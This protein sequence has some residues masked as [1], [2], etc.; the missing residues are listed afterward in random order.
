MN[1]EKR[2]QVFVSST[3]VDLKKEREEVLQALLELDCIPSGMEL[4]PAADETQWDLIKRL[5]DDCDY[6][7]LIIGG[8]YGSIGPDGYSYTEM[9]Y[10]YALEINKPTIA[11]LHRSPGSLSADNT[12]KSDEGRAKLAAFRAFAEQ[13]LC[14]HWEGASDLGGAVV[15]SMNQLIKRRP[16]IGWIRAS[17]AASTEATAEILEL[18][19][20]IERLEGEL[21]KS[22]HSAPASAQGLSSG[23]ALFDLRFTYKGFFS[24]SQIREGKLVCKVSWNN[25][26]GMVAPILMEGATEH[27]MAQVLDALVDRLG[28]PIVPPGLIVFEL[29]A[30]PDDLQTVKIQLR[31]LGLIASKGGKSWILTPYGDQVLTSI[32]A[33]RA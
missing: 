7:V 22:L 25:I 14:K 29:K 6:Y 26:F 15:K 31:A 21:S 24:G 5:I 17:A 8:R 12:E 28:R 18:R 13:K 32:R 19:R 1:S 2:Y 3:F 27:A 11:F 23:E 30:D 16:A 20:K 10:R 4:F 9:E 33:I